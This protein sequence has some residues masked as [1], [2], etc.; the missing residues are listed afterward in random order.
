VN[1]YTFDSPGLPHFG[2]LG[3]AVKFENQQEFFW[4][5]STSPAR[6]TT[7]RKEGRI[8]YD[9]FSPRSLPEPEIFR[10]DPQTF[11]VELEFVPQDSNLI[12]RKLSEK[13][14]EKVRSPP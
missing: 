14:V 9:K 1:I 3:L 2:A 10:F 6:Q 12:L 8:L 5:A 13:S 11:L 7:R 4:M